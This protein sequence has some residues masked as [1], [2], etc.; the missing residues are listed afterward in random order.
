MATG[1][2]VLCDVDEVVVDAE[3]VLV[4]VPVVPDEDEAEAE[5]DDDDEDEDEDEDEEEQDGG[6]GGASTCRSGACARAASER[7]EGVPTACEQTGARIGD[8]R[9][10]EGKSRRSW[11][12]RGSWR[13]REAGGEEAA[14][15]VMER[16]RGGAREEGQEGR[17]KVGQH[18]DRGT[19]NREAGNM[20]RRWR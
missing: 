11:I 14:S 20:R 5:D 1:V 10:G 18:K 12:D 9:E 16:R 4:V 3:E 19:Q 13:V 2:R 6:A 8:G 17:G 7:E 15:A